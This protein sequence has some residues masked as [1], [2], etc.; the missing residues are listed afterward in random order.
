MSSS[1]PPHDA[2]VED[3][4]VI[5]VGHGPVGA[6]LALYL[7]RR[8]HRVVVLER[9]TGPYTLPRA[10]SFDGETARLLAAT[11]VGGRLAD[12]GEPATGYEWRNAAGRP[13][14]RLAFADPGRYGW[15]DATTMHQPHL[16]AALHAQQREHPGL[17]VRHGHTVVGIAD[18]SDR[19]E[20]T[21]ALPDGTTEVLRGAWV[22]GCDGANSFVRKHLDPPGTDLGFSY[23]WLLCDV[24]PYGPVT[25]VPTNIQICDP[26]RPTTLV[27]S[28]HGRRRYEFMRLPGETAAELERPETVWRLLAD[29]G[30]TPEN[31]ELTRSA[32]YTFQASWAERWRSGRVLLAGDAAHLMPPFVGQGMCSGIRDA[33]NLAWKLDAVLRGLAGERLLDTYPVERRRLAKESIVA[34]VKL[35]QVICVTDPAAAADRDASMLTGAENRPAA[36]PDPA[37]SLPQ[38][39]LARDAERRLAVGE[40]VP[41]GRVARAGRVALF[42]EAVGTGLVL[43]ATADPRPA[44]GADRLAALDRWGCRLVHLLPADGTATA[45]QPAPP[46]PPAQPAQVTQPTQVTQV[47][48]VTDTDGVYHAWLAAAGAAAA[49]VR[50]DYHVFGAVASTAGLPGL[51]DEFLHR[52]HYRTQ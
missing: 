34:S 46:A 4:D 15:P 37:E 35:G 5:V 50:P 13:L 7:G 9:R 26:V 45:E 11:G 10:T 51:V 28:G 38:G 44:L 42:D 31:A 16:E 27:G 20:V 43:V 3:P 47:T 1:A 12:V 6:A 29:H 41:Q 48:E 23:D 40:V 22:V 49:L 21:A 36:A 39:L 33:A 32:V 19:V 8:G 25:F 18:H 2:D 17:S 24:V 14:V 52:T 30:V